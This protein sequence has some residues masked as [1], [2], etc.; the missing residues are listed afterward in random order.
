[1]LKHHVRPAKVNTEKFFLGLSPWAQSQFNRRLKYG[2]DLRRR[3]NL[4]GLIFV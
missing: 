3:R 2:L 1:M 4:D